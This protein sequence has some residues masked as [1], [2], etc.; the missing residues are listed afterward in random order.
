MQI[1]D[2]KNFPLGEAF[3]CALRIFV[4]SRHYAL[5]SWNLSEKRK[6]ERLAHLLIVAKI[7]SIGQAKFWH[8]TWMDTH[9]LVPTFFSAG[10]CHFEC[11]HLNRLM[12]CHQWHVMLCMSSVLLC[13]WLAFVCAQQ[14]PSHTRG[15]KQRP[16]KTQSGHA[17]I[18]INSACYHLPIYLATD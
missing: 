17:G 7:A 6:I 8:M 4:R 1:A 18:A 11:C 13:I 3:F 14:S 2:E 10:F 12:C 16:V 5:S 9:W 15:Q